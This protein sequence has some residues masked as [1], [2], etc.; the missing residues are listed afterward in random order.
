MNYFHRVMVNNPHKVGVSVILL[1]VT[2]FI[3]CAM[4]SGS[5][6]P[7]RY[8]RADERRLTMIDGSYPLDLK[9]TD[10]APGVNPNNDNY[11]ESSDLAY[12]VSLKERVDAIHALEDKLRDIEVRLCREREAHEAVSLKKQA[13][14]RE[15]LADK[16][17]KEEEARL[18][19]EERKRI[20]E[21]SALIAE[22]IRLTAEL[23]R[24]KASLG[25]RLTGNG[26][27]LPQYTEMIQ[28]IIDVRTA[29]SKYKLNVDLI[30]AIIMQESGGNPNASN[31]YAK[32][33]MQLEYV[34]VDS[35]VSFGRDQYGE[36]WTEHDRT[37][38][39]KCID[40]AVWVLDGYLQ[41]YNGDYLKTIQA[42]N[43]SHYS[44]DKL[45]K[46]YGDDWMANRIHMAALN[47][48]TKYGDSNYVEHVL[49]YYPNN[50]TISLKN[51]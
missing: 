37:D 4:S 3:V 47:G 42:Y 18:A 8:V 35:F 22:Q 13:L 38:P 25:D 12:S 36:R 15:I 7:R 5:S 21:E 16:S 46:V 17:R 51:Q 32:G 24:S 30:K 9:S 6:D 2:G 41:H 10:I 27:L 34:L 26:E 33:I 11:D 44:L 50:G 20:E 28:G 45:I 49:S 39:F 19:E 31:G 29:N 43:Y 48:R 14:E 40:Y 1:V 23:N